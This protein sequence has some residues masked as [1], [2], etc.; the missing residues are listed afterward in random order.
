MWVFNL[1][2]RRSEENKAQGRFMKSYKHWH[3][4]WIKTNKND[5]FYNERIYFK[6]VTKYI[7]LIMLTNFFMFLLKVVLLCL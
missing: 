3:R 1:H 5:A 2:L 4:K 6:R 7:F